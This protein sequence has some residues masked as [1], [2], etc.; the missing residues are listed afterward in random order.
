MVAGLITALSLSSR[1]NAITSRLKTPAGEQNVKKESPAERKYCFEDK[2]TCAGRSADCSK[3]Y[4][5]L[6][7]VPEL[8]KRI[9]FLNFTYN[10]LRDINTSDFFTNVSGLQT[11]DL[12]E[13]ELQ[14]IHPDAFK[15]FTQLKTL[16]L[17]RNRNLTLKALQPVLTASTLRKLEVSFADVHYLPDDLFITC[18][19]PPPLN[20]T[21][22]I[23]TK[24][25]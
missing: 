24:T 8:P 22:C 16:F 9:R 20:S 23:C 5:N 13:N 18:P 4:G 10:R 21:L 17:N 3:N 12:G 19:P 1:A 15:V 7:F 11:L 14:R 6:T 25:R 2:C